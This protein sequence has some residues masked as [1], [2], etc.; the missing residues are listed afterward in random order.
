[1]ATDRVG[2]VV[3]PMKPHTTQRTQEPR[4]NMSRTSYF[5]MQKPEKLTDLGLDRARVSS[6]R[7]LNWR[8]S[9]VCAAK[10]LCF[11]GGESPWWSMIVQALDDAVG[12]AAS[13]KSRRRW[14]TSAM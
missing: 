10:P 3:N 12:C 5:S 7:S 13:S 1:M 9:S 2:P 6:H 8:R 11:V 4:L 14:P